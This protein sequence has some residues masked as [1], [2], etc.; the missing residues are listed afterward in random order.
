MT[1]LAVCV[2]LLVLGREHPF[3]RL[4]DGMFIAGCGLSALETAANPYIV[5]S[6][7]PRYLSLFQR[8]FLSFLSFLPSLP[9]FP[10]PSPF[11]LPADTPQPEKSQT[12]T[13]TASGIV[14]QP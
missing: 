1:G 14:S 10:F 13:T 9:L 8:G 4:C 6:G 11:P 2:L 7:P 5:A 3:P 12:Q